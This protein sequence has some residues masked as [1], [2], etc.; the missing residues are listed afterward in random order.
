MSD[1]EATGGEMSDGGRRK[2][3]HRMEGSPGDSR[4]GS[5]APVKAGSV[6]TGASR[7]GTPIDQPQCKPLFSFS[8]G[9]S[10]QSDPEVPASAR[11][12]GDGYAI[13]IA[14]LPIPSSH[15]ICL[16]VLTRYNSIRI[17]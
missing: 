16:L 1:G 2:K 13:D 8:F 9:Y 12:L 4:A 11:E 15:W 14:F 5:P 10:C 7:T 17:S 6:S 3:K